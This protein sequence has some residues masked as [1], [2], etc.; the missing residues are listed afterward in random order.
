MK[1]A[2]KKATSIKRPKDTYTHKQQERRRLEEEKCGQ[3]VALKR[4]FPHTYV[5]TKALYVSYNHETLS[6]KISNKSKNESSEC[7][8]ALLAPTTIVLYLLEYVRISINEK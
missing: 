1:M 3:L 5:I 6:T 8:R 2:K 4:S 7:Q